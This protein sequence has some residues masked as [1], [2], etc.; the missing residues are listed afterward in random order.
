MQYKIPVQVENEDPIV[1]WLSLKQL[2]IIMGGWAIAYSIFKSL[3]PKVWWEMALIP[4]LI[5]LWITL[6]IALFKQYEMTFLPFVLAILR[7]NINYKE[8]SWIKWV[9]AFSPLD[10]GIITIHSTTDNTK[11]EFKSKMERIQTLEDNLKKI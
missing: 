4:T 9:D 8:R 11:I 3:E 6:F 2:I 10:I 7:F 5:V 1:F